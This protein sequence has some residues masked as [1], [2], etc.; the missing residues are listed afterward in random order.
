M[1]LNFPGWCPAGNSY[2]LVKCSL[3]L[4]SNHLEMVTQKNT[5]NGANLQY[6]GL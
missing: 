1:A 6:T 4:V 2:V 3:A 5:G